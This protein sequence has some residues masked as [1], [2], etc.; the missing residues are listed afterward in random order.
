MKAQ[1][2]MKFGKRPEL[3]GES[4]GAE[5][6]EPAKTKL[7]EIGTTEIG[8]EIPPRSAPDESSV[9]P[10]LASLTPSSSVVII[11]S[12]SMSLLDDT[13]R[14]LHGLMKSADNVADACN[15]AKQLYSIMRL[16]LDAIKTQMRRD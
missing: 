5:T 12:P 6:T 10:Q 1:F 16:K 9:I 15:C 8:E 7:K 3:P 2:L 4:N 14:H 11:E 13:A